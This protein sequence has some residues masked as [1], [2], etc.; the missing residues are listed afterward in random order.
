MRVADYIV[1]ILKIEGVR[2]VA[3]V[4][5]N[6]LLDMFDA[7]YEHP[8]IPLILTRHEQAGVFM[9][10]GYARSTGET[11]VAVASKGPGRA[12]TFAAIV[13]AF[14][15]CV[16]LVVIFSHSPRKN[17]GKGMLQ[18]LPSLESFASIAKWTFSVP[19]SERIPEA[20]RRA[21]TLARSGRPG[22]VILEITEDI[23]RAD[24][25]GPPY[26]KTRRIRF[27]PDPE[28]VKQAL[29]LIRQSHRPL[30][31]IGRGG[32]Y[33]EAGEELKLLADKYAIPVMTTLAAKGIIPEDDCFSIGF[34][35]YPR[36]VYG[37]EMAR[38][39]AEEADLVLSLGCSFRQHA[40]SRWLPK[41]AKARLIQV[42][43]DSAELNK[44][45]VADLVILS[46][47]KLF[48]LALLQNTPEI[49]GDWR[50]G[51][52]PA[53]KEKIREMKARW[54]K[55]WE[56]RLT[57]SEIPLNPYRVCWD[58][59]QLL[60]RRHTILL[61]DAGTVRAYIAP[62]YEALFPKSFVSIGGTGAMG[63]STPAALGVKLA[64]PEKTVVNVTGDG[65][66]G[67]I[68]ME[69]ET[70]ARY[71]IQVLT[72]ILNNGT[73]NAVRE[74]QA[75][76]FPNRDIGNILGGDYAALA[77]SLGAYGKRVEKPEELKDAIKQALNHP[78][79]AVLDILVNPLESRS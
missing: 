49:F 35:G 38:K 64:H 7:L 74:Y 15:D 13:N 71:G 4:T 58:L 39:Y 16:P 33:A 70:A 54:L 1:E 41:P 14:T 18:E 3:G 50:K 67:M 42:D 11:G 37:T 31:Y 57:S 34:G 6:D 36:S 10:D 66:F 60:D 73:L 68:G 5:G 32:L 69:I 79:P 76:R 56:P 59:G 45:Y 17:L 22:P 8:E 52:G 25:N 77:R 62:H 28:D 29:D 78:G 23:M 46:D 24:I 27:A 75:S 20:L 47:I 48:L 12:N 51:M 30:I 61:H 2:F 72:V 63:W 55:S 9:A 40:T 19:S 21:F 53:V 44:N 65:S 43:V 26:V